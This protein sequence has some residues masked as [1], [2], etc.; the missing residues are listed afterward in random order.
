[1]MKTHELMTEKNLSDKERLEKTNN[2]NNVNGNQVG[3]SILSVN[4]VLDYIVNTH[5]EHLNKMLNEI[6]YF[7]KQLIRGSGPS[8]DN[9]FEIYKISDDFRIK[10][11]KYLSKSNEVYI[12]IT[13]EYERG[14]VSNAVE[15]LREEKELNQLCE[16]MENVHEQLT[17]IS[18]ENALPKDGLDTYWLIIKK[19]RELK[20]SI[21]F[22]TYLIDS[23]LKKMDK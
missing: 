19:F 18:R 21:N 12:N 16:L 5:Y 15:M 17:D 22:Q 11:E 4:S 8:H 10:L 1:M 13:K 14:L 2:I 20:E 23:L 3:L 9:L 6:N 7:S